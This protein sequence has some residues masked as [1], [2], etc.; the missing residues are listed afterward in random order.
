[1]KLIRIIA[2]ALL[3]TTIPAMA[4]EK[5]QF[6]L[7]DLIYGGSNFWSLYPEKMYAAWWG[8]LLVKTEVDKASVI[9]NQKGE[10]IEP[11]TLF[12]A[13]EVNSALTDERVGN[14]MLATFPYPDKTQAML[15]T[16]KGNVVYDWEKKEVVWRTSRL[17][18]ASDEEMEKTSRNTAFVRNWN[19]FV[20]TAD[21]EELQVSTDGSREL[22]YGK[23]VHRDE[24]GISKGTFWSPK[25]NRLAFYRMDQS[26]VADYPQVNIDK[27]PAELDPDK[28]PMAG[29]TSH[30]VTV[31]V[32]D[33]ATRET[34]YLQAGDPTDRYFSNIAWAP[35]EKTIYMV[36]SPRSQDKMELVS[37]DA[38]TGSRL[39]VHYTETHPKYVEPLTPITFLPWDSNKF[40]LQ[41]QR[42]G[43][44]H[45]YLFD[46]ENGL[47]RQLTSGN[48]VVLE[49]TGFNESE[50]SVIIK[51]NE[52]ST[53]GESYYSVNVK[54]GKRTLLD[55]GSGTHRA[56]LSANGKY[57]FDRWSSPKVV[58]KTDLV[59]TSKQK[60]VNLL[61]ADDPWKDYD[62]PEITGGTL[63]AADG[64]TDLYYRLIKPTNFDPAKKYPVVIYVYGGPHA[65]MVEDARNYSAGGWEIYMAQLGYVVFVMDN[66][67]SADR[68]LEFENVTF[69]HLGQNEMK[70]QMKGVEFLKSLPYVDG[71]RIGVHGWS[72]GGFMTTSLMCNYPDVFK[73]G[74][75]GGPVIDWKYY[76]VMY[77]E[78]YMDT[79]DENPEG[80]AETSLLNKADQLK[81]RLQIIIGYNDPTCVPQHTLS[82]LKACVDAGTHPDFFAY[83]GHGHNVLGTDR[84]HLHERI[85]RYFEDYLKPIR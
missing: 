49:L 34:V 80:Y 52:A 31:G 81:G 38:T 55:S 29:Q 74:V 32:Y 43:Y 6:T 7:D 79:P 33:V 23:S 27:T 71:E 67:G 13:G 11:Q 59:N 19:L 46:V 14:L 10:T 30:K 77:G 64:T 70:D 73:V 21:G 50:K 68:G 2:T 63:K 84:V 47:E 15:P 39:K 5:K 54:N 26:M 9:S 83:P 57:L 51:S 18:G 78:R 12:T 40:I 28:Y 42:D 62:V 58:S 60:T 48:F 35:D 61:T 41:S 24:F 82:F 72:F 8:D 3:L 37:Y 45:L 76:E 4:Q 44:N 22:Q 20:R 56:Q 36:E 1:M 65:Q 75:A 53:I 85:T 16:S 25:G 66:R 69:R 17:E